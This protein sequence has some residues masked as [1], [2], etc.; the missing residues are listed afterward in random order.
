M[1]VNVS[2]GLTDMTDGWFDVDVDRMTSRLGRKGAV[3]QNEDVERAEFVR[4]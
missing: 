1:S 4:L 2:G 3:A